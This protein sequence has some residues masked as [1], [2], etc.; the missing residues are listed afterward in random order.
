MRSIDFRVILGIV[1]VA[2]SFIVFPIILEGTDTILSNANISD[3]TGLE[4]IVKIA[5]ML[6][7]VGLIFGGGLLIWKGTS[8]TRK[9]RA[10]AKKAKRA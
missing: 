3:Y 1:V 6:V 9:R 5:P 7:M 10:S 8:E 2:I 4:A